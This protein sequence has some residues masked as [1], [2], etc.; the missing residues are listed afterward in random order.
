MRSNISV[1]LPIDLLIY[2]ATSL[3]VGQLPAPVSMK[4]TPTST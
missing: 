3:Q 2:A 1:G 4:A